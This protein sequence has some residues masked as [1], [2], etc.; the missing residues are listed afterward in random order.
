M[1]GI[2]LFAVR[3]LD[4]PEQIGFGSAEIEMIGFGFTVWVMLAVDVHPAVVPV[5]V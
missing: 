4:C 3:V 2:L 5:R 1:E